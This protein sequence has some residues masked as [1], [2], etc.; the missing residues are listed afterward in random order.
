MKPN[1]SSDDSD[2]SL[3]AL[4]QF[5][6]E[7]KFWLVSIPFTVTVIAAAW[8]LTIPDTYRSDTL[9]APTEEAQ[10]AGLKN[11]VGQFGGLASIAGINLDSDNADNVTVAIAILKSRL[12]AKNVI[13]KYDLAVPLVAATGWDRE[14]NTLIIDEQQYDPLTNEWVRKNEPLRPSVPSDQELY[15]RYVEILQI[16]RDQVNGLI[17]VSVEFFSPVLSK[18]WLEAMIFEINEEMRNRE[19]LSS[20]QNIEYLQSKVEEL[21][22]IEMVKIFYQLIE[23]ETKDLMLAEVTKDY[24]FRTLDPPVVAIKKYAPSRSLICLVVAFLSGFLI[25][26]GYIAAFLLF[27]HLGTDKAQ[28]RG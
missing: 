16:E 15:E 10:G 27:P 4:F 5:L 2:L 12:F 26:L 8:T 24:V 1:Q 7:Q 21:D 13:A 3:L 14:S 6:W 18:N 22:N 19:M 9:L 20:Q 23:Q 28:R 17:T 25:L 11:M